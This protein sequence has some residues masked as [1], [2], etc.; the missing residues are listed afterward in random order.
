MSIWKNADIQPFFWG[1]YDQSEVDYIENTKGKLVA[2][3][4]KWNNKPK[5]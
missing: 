5:N 4:M 2:Y 3:E 1:N